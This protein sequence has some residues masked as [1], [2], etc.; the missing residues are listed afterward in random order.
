MINAKYVVD[1]KTPRTDWTRYTDGARHFDSADA[2][3]IARAL[4]IGFGIPPGSGA[5][6]AWNATVRV[7][8][9]IGLSDPGD[10]PDGEYVYD[11]LA[12]YGTEWR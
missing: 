9:W 10:E 11:A 2:N 4:A 8:V 6:I 5:H 7:R 12:Q 3:E 1:C